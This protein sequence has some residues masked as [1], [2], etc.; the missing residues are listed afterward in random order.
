[1]RRLW[2]IGLLRSPCIAATFVRKFPMASRMFRFCTGSWCLIPRPA[3]MPE[4][5]Q[6]MTCDTD[7]FGD[8]IGLHRAYVW[9][10]SPLVLTH[11][12]ITFETF[13]IRSTLIFSM[14]HV[15]LCVSFWLCWGCPTPF[16]KP[17]VSRVEV[18]ASW[19]TRFDVQS[20]EVKMDSRVCWRELDQRLDRIKQANLDKTKQWEKNLW[21]KTKQQIPCAVSLLSLSTQKIVKQCPVFLDWN[22]CDTNDS[23]VLKSMI[24]PWKDFVNWPSHTC[25]QRKSSRRRW[26]WLVKLGALKKRLC[27]SMNK[28]S[29]T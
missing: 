7:I 8:E 10:P 19:G 29:K 20:I 22:C 11:Q 21:E 5:W 2:K 25:A 15:N 18:P 6:G 13:W 4:Q 3:P 12:Y 9:E 16:S 28:V 24:Q 1:M 17:F 23:Q 14:F 26:R 27:T